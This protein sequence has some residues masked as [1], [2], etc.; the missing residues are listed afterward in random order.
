MSVAP[1]SKGGAYLL[2]GREEFLK[3]EFIQQLR[4]SLFTNP[5][6]LDMGFRRFE[7]PDDSA[8]ALID[9]A[10]SVSF[11]STR[12]LAVFWGIDE[13]EEQDKELL[14]NYAKQVPSNTFLVFVSEESSIKKDHFLKVLSENAKATPCHLPFDKDLPQWIE[15]RFRRSKKT[16]SREAIPLVLERAGKDAALLSSA[17]E[18]LIIYVNERTHVTFSDVEKLLGRSVQSDVFEL[19]DRLFDKKLKSSL[20]ILDD[21]LREGT[22][23]YE[24]VGALAGQFERIARIRALM[25]EGFSQETIIEDLR[26]HPFFAAKILKQ[27]GQVSQERIRKFR[28]DLLE[29]DRDV[30]TGRLSDRMALQ[31]FLLKTYLA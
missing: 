29:C 12:K 13:L 21:L 15:A 25:D 6:D 18:Q 19:I 10:G 20:E 23:I 7:A 17:I 9:F 14:L 28:S 30:K 22:K 26:L 1:D 27:A 11:F 31:R 3:R 5:Q 4:A 24:I 8:H 16:V 2:Y